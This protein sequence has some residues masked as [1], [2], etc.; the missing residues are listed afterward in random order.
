MSALDHDL[1]DHDNHQ[2]QSLVDE[3]AVPLPPILSNENDDKPLKDDYVVSKSDKKV[4]DNTDNQP[5]DDTPMQQGR[6]HN[7]TNFLVP[8]TNDM[9]KT[10]L[11]PTLAKSKFD[12]FTLATIGIQLLL[13]FSLGGTLRRQSEQ[14]YIVEWLVDSGLL[15]SEERHDKPLA[16]PVEFNAWLLFRQL[17]DLVLCNDFVSYICFAL[18]CMDGVTSTGYFWADMLRWLVGI[19]LLGFN[20]WVKSDAHRVVK[21]FAWYWGDFFFIIDQSLTFDGVFEMAPHP[22][23]SVGYAGY[24]GISLISNSYAV[25]FVSLAA[26]TLQFLF[27][28][29][30]E[31]PHIDKIYNQPTKPLQTRKRAASDVAPILWDNMLYVPPQPNV[32]DL[33]RAY[34]R[35]DLIVFRNFDVT[36]SSDLLT[37]AIIFYSIVFAAFAPVWRFLHTY[38]LGWVLWRQNTDKWWVRRRIMEGGSAREAFTSWKRVY[39]L[40][41]CMTYISSGLA[42]WVMYTLPY[43]WTYG[44]VIL[45][46][47]LGVVL[48]AL[49]IWTAVSVFEV[50]G[51]FGWFYGDFFIK[52]YP[53]TL[54]YTGIYR[55]LN[56]PEKIMG[57]AAF[58]GLALVA[59]HWSIYTL[60]LFSQVSNFLFLHYVESPHMKL[61]YGDRIR[62]EAGLTKNVRRLF[63]VLRNY[64][65]TIPS[66]SHAINVIEAQQQ[67]LS[68][69]SQAKTQQISD[70]VQKLY[71]QVR[72]YWQTTIKDVQLA[73]T[74]PRVSIA[75]TNAKEELKTIANQKAYG[76]EVIGTSSNRHITTDKGTTTRTDKDWIGVYPVDANPSKQATTAS[77][78]ALWRW[79]PKNDTTEGELVFERDHMPFFAGTYEFRYHHHGKYTVLARSKAMEIT[80]LPIPNDPQLIQSTLLDYVQRC[81]YRDPELMPTS[82]EDELPMLTDRRAGYIVHGIRLMYG[83]KFRP[84]VIQMDGTVGR[85]CGRINE[86]IRILAK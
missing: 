10:I 17:V 60:V 58:W 65:N 78:H 39:N 54:Y 56:N 20:I 70:I 22:M 23:Y 73:I 79:V 18:A 28:A 30:V 82:M 24:Y 2:Q 9:L 55:F 13:F 25:L 66:I 59:N 15:A 67:A 49:H 12:L 69:Y 33:H 86:A 40:T 37:V 53:S 81:Y 77:S 3:S 16:V 5:E 7:G 57:H 64:L 21:D 38:G 36:R 43:D 46:H 31:N 50:L 74:T 26:H 83:V 41:L 1:T 61:L 75:E 6:T 29:I 72:Q 35:R 48:I 80:V 27:L 47:V 8:K 34:F 76:I 84:A 71:Q 51:D 11:D 32:H 42:G 45:R 44:S 85:I 63:T 14:N 52:E 19:V 4:D 62:E 68:E